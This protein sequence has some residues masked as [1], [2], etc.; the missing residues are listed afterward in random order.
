M[1]ISEGVQVTVRY[2]VN[3]SGVIV[4]NTLADTT[5]IPGTTGGQL[6]RRVSSSLDLQRN[7]Y[8][9]TEIRADRQEADFRLGTG[10]VQGDIA[11]ELSPGTYFD[12]LE[13]AHRDTKVAALTLSNTDLTTCTGSHSGSTFTF[14]SG[15]PVALGLFV[16]D[17][18]RFTGLSVTADDA[19]NF[20]IIS[21]GGTTN[22]TVTVTPAPTDQSADSAWS[23]VRV[24]KAT[25]IPSANH[26]SR[27]FTFE[28]YGSDTDYSQLFTEN[29][30]TK[31]ALNLPATG[32]ATIT[33][34]VMGRWAYDLSGGSAPYFTSPTAETTTTLTAAV[35]GILLLNGA[36]VGTITGVQITNEMQATVGE[37]IGQNFPAAI[38]LGHNMVTGQVTAYLDG[39]TIP[40]L[41]K[42]ET[43]C[44]L[45]VQLNATSAPDSPIIS[46]FL[47]RIKFTGAPAPAQGEGLQTITAQFR[48]LK[49]NGSVAGYPV[50]TIRIQDS[51]AV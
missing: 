40:V 16:G 37:V 35:N 43:E 32:L 36:Q 23:L 50:T 34:S 49:Y 29:R 25:T 20:T 24:G 51:E 39:S 13:A 14:G 33:I 3:A 31:Y 41:F 26:V 44:Q 28:H 1:A 6:L 18:I 47:P 7:N 46:I 10:H 21:F 45:L 17:V 42:T 19:L 5:S 12:F 30:I 48:A 8:A 11:G 27:L 38:S 4:A 2:K 15:D 22:E 9:A